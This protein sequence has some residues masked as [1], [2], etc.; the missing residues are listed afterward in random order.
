MGRL[1]ADLR[2]GS[3]MDSARQN[4]PLPEVRQG[5]PEH[6]DP[7]ATAERGDGDMTAARPPNTQREWKHGHSRIMD[8]PSRT[9]RIWAGMLTR[10]RNPNHKPGAP[11][12]EKNLDY[13]PRWNDFRIFL[14]DMGECP[15]G[16]S[17][18]R[19]DNA[20]GYW[21]SN[22]RWAT[23]PM[24]QRNTSRNIW[25]V[26]SG[27]R[28][29]IKDALRQLGYTYQAYHYLRHTHGFSAQQTIDRFTKR[30]KTLG[31]NISGPVI[32]G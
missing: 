27:E 20:K 1:A 3:D 5:P 24:Q 22:C 28:M 2:S 23:R 32:N 14:S 26:L 31:A 16:M 6:P 19:I 12:R 17:I 10:M 8:R 30:Q 15:D 11:Y 7:F 25:V 29:V 13:D 21:P 9:Y 4:L 18:D